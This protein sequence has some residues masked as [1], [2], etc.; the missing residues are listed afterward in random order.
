[1]HRCDE[2]LIYKRD[3]EFAS[4]LDIRLSICRCG[5][6]S[7]SIFTVREL[8]TCLRN[9]FCAAYMW[10]YKELLGN[11]IVIPA[12][13]IHIH[14]LLPAACAAVAATFGP[15]TLEGESLNSALATRLSACPA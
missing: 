12:V 11:L 5:I 15:S 4:F 7:A 1:M 8:E 9:I 13:S 2:V 14:F 3:A 10:G 6:V